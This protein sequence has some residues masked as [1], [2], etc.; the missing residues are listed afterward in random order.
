MTTMSGSQWLKGA[1]LCG[2]ILAA[3]PAAVVAQPAHKSGDQC[4]L[5]SDVN[6]FRASDEST[7]YLRAGVN[8]VYRLDLM[9]HCLDL[10]F[11]DAIGLESTPGNPWICSPLDAT[12]IYRNN[13]IAQRC[14]VSALHKLTP[15]ELAALPKRDRP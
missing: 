11:R 6:G 4:F 5:S 1:V 3:A 12:V 13:G 10:T 9:T 2:I 8:D 14:P 15:A 7:L